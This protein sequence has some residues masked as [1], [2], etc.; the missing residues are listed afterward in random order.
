MRRLGRG[1]QPAHD[2]TPAARARTAPSRSPE[3]FLVSLRAAGEAGQ[4]GSHRFSTDGGCRSTGRRAPEAVIHGPPRSGP[5]GGAE[6]ECRAIQTP[7]SFDR[8]HRSTVMPT[9]GEPALRRQR[10]P[11]TTKDSVGATVARS[12]SSDP[13][14]THDVPPGASGTRQA[15]S[16]GATPFRGR[17]GH[18]PRPPDRR[19]R[20]AS[21][22]APPFRRTG[23][24]GPGR[25]P[26]TQVA[27]DL[28]PSS[29]MDGSNRHWGATGHPVHTRVTRNARIE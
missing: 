12:A 20:P 9:A 2:G 16:A 18:C 7:T 19:C 25:L 10:R 1:R 6:L 5:V 23:V 15:G 17:S 4:P 11:Q 21:N 8:P 24:D 22:P 26:L 29:G 3:A 27:V 14:S 13:D 28:G